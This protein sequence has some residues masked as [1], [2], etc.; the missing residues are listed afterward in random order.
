MRIL[1]TLTLVSSIGS[2]AL[3]A[4]AQP[5]N[6]P[7]ASAP[8][9]EA[10]KHTANGVRRSGPAKRGTRRYA[11]RR[12]PDDLCS[13]VNGWR[14]FPLVP[15]CKDHLRNRSRTP[16]VAIAI[17]VAT[18]HTVA[19]AI[20]MA[21]PRATRHSASSAGATRQ[22]SQPAA[23]AMTAQPPAK[24][25]HT[26][27]ASTN[28]MCKFQGQDGRTSSVEWMQGNTAQTHMFRSKKLK[29]PRGIGD[30]A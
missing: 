18:A 7:P 9:V 16:R 8:K 23:Q 6:L 3:P 15:A 29:W 2:I 17:T 13:I 28:R 25:S 21:A 20:A 5:L 14:A 30:A 11:I 1:L 24:A 10:V 26:I 12:H 19:A 27:A 22:A 4:V